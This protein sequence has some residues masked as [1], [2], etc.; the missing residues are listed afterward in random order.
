MFARLAEFP[1]LRVPADRAGLRGE[2][3]DRVPVPISLT[4]E[5][6]TGVAI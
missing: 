6:S 4:F 1:S 3:G 2:A 5:Y